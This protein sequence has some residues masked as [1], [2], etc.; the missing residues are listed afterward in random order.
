MNLDVRYGMATNTSLTSPPFEPWETSQPNVMGEDILGDKYT[1]SGTNGDIG[2]KALDR[3]C[4]QNDPFLLTISF[5][6]PHAPMVAASKYF[7]YYWNNR[8]NLLVPQSIDDN[9]NNSA[10][11]SVN[12]KLLNAG[13]GYNDPAQVQ[14]WTAC[15]YS[16]VEEI[17]NWIGSMLAT[18]DL[19]P[20]VRDNTLIIFTSDHGEM[21]GAHAMREKNIF[22]EESAHVPLIAKFPGHI[23]AGT[24]VDESV[25]TLDVFSTILDYSNASSYDN[26]DG[27]SLRGFIEKTY[28]NKDYDE[29]HIV[30][31]WDFRAPRN[32]NDLQRSLGG[33]INFLSKKGPYKLMMTKKASSTKLDMMY[34]LDDD[35]YEMDNLVG[36]DGMTASDEVIGKAEHLKALLIDWM[37]R[38]DG[39]DNLYSDPVWNNGEGLGDI[40]EIRTRRKWKELDLWVSDR[41]VVVGTPANVLGT[42]TRN[43]W[44]YLGRGTNGTTNVSSISVEGADAGKFA[45]SS[46]TGG[47]ISQ[48]AHEKIKV[49]YTP[50]SQDEQI[51]DARIRIQ[52]NAGADILITLTNTSGVVVLDNCDSDAG[53][54][55]SNTLTVDTQN[56]QEGD[57]CLREWAVE[58]TGS[59]N[60]LALPS[61]AMSPKTTGS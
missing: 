57:A 44:I 31:E 28:Y 52:H 53:W 4:Q 8:T 38:M 12:R 61:T 50:L 14:E 16:L 36:D 22:L 23:S 37:T 15:Y 45:L 42:W 6:N 54:G 27:K 51:T 39:T 18:L 58:Q 29:A 20:D 49:Q 11:E 59:Q 47:N 48:N 2:V 1:P 24:I 19:Y 25:S 17:D 13:Y 21:L 35:P 56:K 33:E 26:S 10:Y 5:H 7:D 34:N 46:F 55:S 3:L 9:M 60:N 40:E 41:T 32:A 30:T 43:E